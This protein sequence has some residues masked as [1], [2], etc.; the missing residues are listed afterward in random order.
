MDQQVHLDDTVRNDM[1]TNEQPVSL[2]SAPISSTIST[3]ELVER[4]RHMLEIQ[5]KVMKKGIHYDII[6]GCKKP[7][8]L[9]P[10]AQL[11]CVAFRLA[12]QPE[13]V[14]LSTPD[15]AKYRVITKFY[16]QIN[17]SFLGTGVGEASSNEDKYAW[18]QVVCEAEW[19]ATKESQRRLKFYKNGNSTKQIHN[20][21]AD[22]ANTVL[23]MAAKRSL[24]NG[25]LNILAASEIFSQDLED[26]PAG[27]IQDNTITNDSAKQKRVGQ[28]PKNDSSDFVSA[29]ESAKPASS[30]DLA[31]PPS[32]TERKEMS[33]ISR[34]QEKRLFALLK[35]SGITDQ[36][37][38]IW[39]KGIVRK[40]HPYEITWKNQEYDKIC[41]IIEKYPKAIIDFKPKEQ[42][43]SSE[44][45]SKEE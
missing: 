41:N 12:N 18:K 28:K 10:G 29:S 9:Q 30:T 38:D 6:F 34:N 33:L 42:G 26:L 24:V 14:D 1:Q 43:D 16:D 17:G 31:S 37:F 13:V 22:V 36:Q 35:R 2:Q 45:E 3:N 40:E 27:I 23:K 19:E 20:N 4:L 25:V 5:K 15:M 44:T 7:S 32:D 8:L 39:L 21:S 11:L